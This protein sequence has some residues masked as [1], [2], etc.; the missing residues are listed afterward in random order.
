MENLTRFTERLSSDYQTE[1]LKRFF[2]ENPTPVNYG[3]YKALA[4]SN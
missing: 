4:S 2:A 1:V 3:A